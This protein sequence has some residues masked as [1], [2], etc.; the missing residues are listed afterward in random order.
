MI[1]PYEL[2]T[3]ITG[4]ARELGKAIPD[5]SIDLIFTD[6]PYL[7]E[8]L[9]LYEWLAEF[10]ARVLKPG[11]FCLAMCGGSYLN[12]IFRM[13][14]KH[15]TFFWKYEIVLQGWATG[16]VWTKSFPKTTITVRSKPLLAY[17]KGDNTPR[18][19]T[20]SSFN[21]TG[22][23]KRYHVWGQDEASTR[24][25]V[26]CFSDVGQI[27]LDPFCGGGTTPAMA[28]LLNRHWLAFEK[29]KKAASTARERVKIIT[30]YLPH[31]EPEQ[32][33]LV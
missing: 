19:S 8:Y 5:N 11:G 12:Q 21:G 30:P 23:D 13:M 29:D 6:P 20:V 1:G 25:Y 14:D 26:D 4:D 10:S 28:R 7:K 17:S 2:N 9:Y 24:Y 32:L 31:I 16:I 15:L 3:I 33:T 27:V 22:G 18:T